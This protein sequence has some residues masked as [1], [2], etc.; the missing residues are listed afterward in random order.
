MS[1]TRL[2][3]GVLAAWL[4]TA[5]VAAHAADLP[6]E[7]PPAAVVVES[8]SW[9]GVYLG[10]AIG[11]AF[12]DLKVKN[13][14]LGDKFSYRNDVD[15][16]MGSGFIGVNYEVGGFVAGAEADISYADFGGKSRVCPGGSIFSCK[17]NADNWFGTVRGRLGFAF[18]RFLVFG[19]GGLAIGQD[20]DFKRTQSALPSAFNFSKDKSGVRYGYVLGGGV[21]YAVTDHIIVR[22]EYQYVDFGSDKLRA[23]NAFGGGQPARI[24][25]DANIIRA[26][27]AYKF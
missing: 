10:G 19:T 17:A 12:S 20:V 3:G 23:K 14:G 8:F 13:N 21:D 1:I 24:D 4:A 11:Y 5:G 27:V 26:G 7:V 6:L 15:S 16:L 18:D 22:A 2:S 25:Q 9:S